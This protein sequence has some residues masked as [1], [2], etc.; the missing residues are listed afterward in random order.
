MMRRLSVTLTILC[1]ASMQ[2]LAAEPAPPK[3]SSQPVG[4]VKYDLSV[5]PP[6]IQ[7]DTARDYQSFIAVVRRSDDVT[8]DVTAEAA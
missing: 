8:H 7:L 5:F 3:R 2:G 4:K 6:Q 1:F